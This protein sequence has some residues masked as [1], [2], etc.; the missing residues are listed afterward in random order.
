[1]KPSEH[2]IE[3]WAKMVLSKPTRNLTEEEARTLVQVTLAQREIDSDK[4]I[5]EMLEKK[6]A[7]FLTSILWWRVKC[8]HTYE[9]TPSLCVYLGEYVLKNPGMSTMMANYLQY[10]ASKQN[11]RK[12]GVKEFSQYAFPWG[13]PTDDSWKELWDAQK[14]DLEIREDKKSPYYDGS[15]NIL[16]YPKLYQTIAKIS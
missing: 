2:A 15:D 10:V 12:I 3:D 6:Q 9:I 11:I 4:E 1:M 14:I 8:C 16:D 13:L 5:F 7:G